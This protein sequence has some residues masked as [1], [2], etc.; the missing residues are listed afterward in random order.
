M[1]AIQTLID[2]RAKA[3][4]ASTAI[5]DTAEAEGRDLT[6]EERSAY[7][8]ADAEVDQLTA[9]IERWGKNEARKATFTAETTLPDGRPEHRTIDADQAEAEYR[10]AYRSWVREGAADMTADQKAILRSGFV[11]GKEFRAQGVGTASA[12][13]YLVPEDFRAKIIEKQK[14]YGAVQQVAEVLHTSTGAALPWPTN[15]DTGNVGA[16]LA[17]NTQISEQDVVLGTAQLGAYMYT[18]KLVRVS[19]QFL[20]DVDWLNTETWLAGKFGQRLGRILNQHFTTGTGSAQPQGIVTGAVSGKTAAS[21]TAVTTDE[22]I[23]LQHSVDPAYRNANSAFMFGDV[24]LA[25]LRKLKDG[26]GQ[27]LW[28]PSLQAGVASTFLGSNYVIN[29]DM[30][31]PAAGVKSVLYGD[32]KTGYVVRIVKEMQTVRLNERYADYLQVGFFAFERA[33]GLVQDTSAYKALTQAA[34]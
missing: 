7:D 16:L 9:D 26:D 24:T 15:D 25:A 22:L 19:Y 28:Q 12:G 34:S 2:K 5:L 3:W 33:D 13:G 32:F 18:S 10:E 31:T 14:A 21:T 11:D 17:E 30:A 27:Y 8:A 1:T 20:Q 6:A 4:T 23:D 29:V